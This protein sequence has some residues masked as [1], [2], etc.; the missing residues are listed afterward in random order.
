MSRRLF[1]VGGSIEFS[2]APTDCSTDPHAVS[3]SSSSVGVPAA[4]RAGA[5]TYGSA[6]YTDA[7]R[8]ET[9]SADFDQRHAITA[10]GSYC[11]PDSTSV[12]AT[13]RIGTGVPI[14]GYLSSRAGNLFIG[15]R[16][17]DVRLS[18]H[19][20]FRPG[21][22]DRAFRLGGRRLHAF[23]E[24]VNLFDNSNTAATR[25]TFGPAANRLGSSS[26]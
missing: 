4:W 22:A 8:G 26:D 17:N 10:F 6:R 1:T 15:E 23:V 5:R 11:W 24:V 7:G 20:P 2:I 21:G 14:P 12:G 13:L 9:F 3:S 16:R 25:G 18:T 19:L